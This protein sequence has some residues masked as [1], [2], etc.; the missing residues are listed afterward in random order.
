MMFL[1]R[2]D[3][4]TVLSDRARATVGDGCAGGNGEG[5]RSN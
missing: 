5:W 2:A 1:F 3:W 4:A